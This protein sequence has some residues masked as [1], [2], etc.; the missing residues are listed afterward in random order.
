MVEPM[1]DN[2]L[3]YMI[4]ESERIIIRSS[5]DSEDT[6]NHITQQHEQG[7]FCSLDDIKKA[8]DNNE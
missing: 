8:G 5:K 3:K 6:L 1:H 4:P 7:D 2:V